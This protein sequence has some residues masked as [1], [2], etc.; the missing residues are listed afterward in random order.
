MPLVIRQEIPTDYPAIRQVVESAFMHAEHTDHDE[1]NLVERLRLT[2]NYIPELALVAELDGRLVGHILFTRVQ[3]GEKSLLC[4]APVAVL[5]DC[6][7]KGVG[8]AL[9]RTGHR[10]AAELGYTHCVLVGHE[11][12]YPRFGYVPAGP[13]GLRC[14]FPVPDANFMVHVLSGPPQRLEGVVVFS[15][16]FGL[17]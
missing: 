15:P 3:V 5:P 11:T 2:D 17:A 6:Q 1:Q 14:P 7:G 16:A 4:L 8:G 10:L 13:L 9:I 12:Y